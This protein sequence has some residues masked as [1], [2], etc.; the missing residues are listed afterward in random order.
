MLCAGC[1]SKVSD[2]DVAA[3]LTENVPSGLKAV[4]A[5]GPTQAHISS[6]NDNSLV[7]FKSQ[8]KLTQPLFES[9]D[10]GTMAKSTHSDIS[11]LGKIEE[12]AQGLAPAARDELAADIEKATR[13][14]TFI[15]QTAKA[16]DASDWYGSFT[17]KSFGN[18]WVW[19]DFKTLAEPKLR[20]QP[21]TAFSEAAI[22]ESNAKTWFAESRARQVD[23]LQEIEDA[24]SP[25]RKT[26][27]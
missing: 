7:E 6:T 21:R 8:L 4:V 24:K 20:G 26:A 9:V 25:Y 2:H 17:R 5:V 11:L 12:R 19:S 27:K 23:V 10:F 3:V 16:G 15:V 14:P 1:S 22:D 13:I 18:M